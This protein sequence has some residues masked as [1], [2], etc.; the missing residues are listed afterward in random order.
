M[1]GYVQ[2]LP[3]GWLV[4]EQNDYLYEIIE[5]ILQ[6]SSDRELTIL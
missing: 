4:V 5:L 6:Y 1:D 3:E 2:G